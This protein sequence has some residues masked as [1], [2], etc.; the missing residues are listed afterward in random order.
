MQALA[1]AAEE[2]H[3]TLTPGEANEQKYQASTEAFYAY[4]ELAESYR[5]TYLAPLE[6]LTDADEAHEAAIRTARTEY[7]ALGKSYNGSN[8]SKCVQSF[9]EPDDLTMLKNLEKAAQPEPEGREEGHKP[10]LQ[11]SKHDAPFTRGGA[12]GHRHGE[13]ARMTACLRRRGALLKMWT[14]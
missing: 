3:V 4:K 13:K 6:T 11:A 14:R 2:K 12:Q 5:K 8:V 9:I 10:D 7:Q 1:S